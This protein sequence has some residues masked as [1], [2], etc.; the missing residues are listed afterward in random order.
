VRTRILNTVILD[1]IWQRF[2]GRLVVGV[3]TARLYKFT[4]IFSADEGL[5]SAN[6]WFDGLANESG[7]RLLS[8]YTT[9]LARA[10][11]KIRQ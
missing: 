6:G 8:I 2:G 11:S 7:N 1:L 4:A 10:R 5:R 9:I 3:D